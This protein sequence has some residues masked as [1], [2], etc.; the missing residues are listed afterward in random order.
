MAGSKNRRRR[1]MR[2]QIARVLKSKERG[3]GVKGP[4]LEK[5]EEVLEIRQ[6]DG[7]KTA[8]LCGFCP[9]P[10]INIEVVAE[11]QHPRRSPLIHF[12][13]LRIASP[14]SSH[15]HPL[16]GVKVPPK[17]RRACSVNS[18]CIFFHVA[19]ETT[20]ADQLISGPVESP[21]LQGGDA[22]ERG[23]TSLP[24]PPPSDSDLLYLMQA[25]PLSP[26]KYGA[27]RRV[28]PFSHAA[29]FPSL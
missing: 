21:D 7:G 11:K 20:L 15:F 29:G 3:L 14:S 12:A 24:A 4:E 16:G 19:V 10:Y 8:R 18:C 27:A 5:H 6:Q 25:P 9:P 23:L 13:I 22:S 26:A 2:S 1:P 17:Y 28:F